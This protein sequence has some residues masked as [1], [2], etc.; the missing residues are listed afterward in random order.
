MKKTAPTQMDRRSFLQVTALAGGG[1]IIGMY[2]PTIAQ[3][4]GGRGGPQI[5]WSLAPNDY[6]TVHPDNTFTII[7]KNPETGQGIR[8]A[9]PQ[10][11]ADEFDVDWSQV[12]IQQA[13]L[14]PKYGPQFEG[15]SRA[16]PTNYEPLRQVGAGGRLMMVTAAAQQWNVPASELTTGSGVVT[17]AASKRTATYASLAPRVASMTPPSADAAK[18]AVKDPKNFKIIGK[19]IK[20]VDNAA[21][22][23]GKPSFSIDLEPQGTLFAVFEKCPVFG[24]KV[25]SANLDDVKKLPGIKHA[26]VVEPAGQGNNALA[27]GVAIVADSWWMANNARR[28]LKVVWDEGPVATQSSVGYAAQAKQLSSKASQPPAPAAGGRGAPPVAAIGDAEAA[29]GNAAKV[30]EAEYEFGLLSHAPLEPQNSL[31]HYKSDGTLEIWSC[32]QIPSAANPAL[33]AGITPDKVTFHLVRA[34]GGF[35]RRLTSDYDVEVGKIA[36]VVTEERAKAGQPSV[37]VKLLWTREDDL[38]H[39]QYRPG[40]FHYFKAGLDA[41]GKLVAFRDFV[42]S[43]ASVVPANEFPRGFVANFSVHSAPITPFDIPTGALRAPGT[44]GVSFV[45]QSFIDEIAI[46]ANKDPLQYRLDLLANATG[47]GDPQFNAA[48]ARGVLEAVRD[49]SDWNNRSKL[50]KGTGKGVAFQFAHSGYVAYVVEVQVGDDK[51]INITKAWAAVDIGRQIVNPSE[52]INLVQG[53]FIEAM[54]H[55]MAWQITIDKGRVVQRNFNN[56]QPT[57]MSQIPAS[58]D[59]KFL[60]TDFEVTGLGEPALPPAIPAISNAIFAATG[61]RIRSVPLN[62]QGYGWV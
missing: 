13:D 48:R 21:I 37:P 11:I 55:M 1:V 9:L 27:S 30:I 2:A 31:A 18:A 33:G 40:G 28:T 47:Q 45:M 36:R 29:F 3:Q 22:V 42:A 49:M 8:T 4:G 26:F 23:T 24:G 44:N 60:Q 14:N 59:V 41:S 34:G 52:S 43:T 38:G 5:P 32:S 53:A 35:G 57:R 12:K 51:K 58:V 56:Y 39:D 16:M 62:A 17:H 10:I 7:A 50:P 15:G 19:P 6:I 20:G 25:M 46:A 61:V 54:S